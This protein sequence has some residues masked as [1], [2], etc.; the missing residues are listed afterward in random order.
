MTKPAL[1]H[2]DTAA[3]IPSRGGSCV[4][5]GSLPGSFS[6]PK[7]HTNTSLRSSPATLPT[8]SPWI[9]SHHPSLVHGQLPA[10]ACPLVLPRGMFPAACTCPRRRTE[11]PI[12]K[13]RAA[14]QAQPSVPAVIKGSRKLGMLI[15]DARLHNWE[16]GREGGG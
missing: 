5:R 13:L 7:H 6:L 3:H 8:N 12:C 16:E 14:V 15:R 1:R 9:H 4:Q 10:T 11:Q 2:Q